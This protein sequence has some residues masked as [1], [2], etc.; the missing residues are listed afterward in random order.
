MLLAALHWTDTNAKAIGHYAEAARTVQTHA[1]FMLVHKV[2]HDERRFN[3]AGHMQIE[4]R[5]AD[6]ATDQ[7]GRDA[8]RG[9]P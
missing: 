6:I 3:G 4:A 8:V 1:G 5:P 2:T 9:R 7:A